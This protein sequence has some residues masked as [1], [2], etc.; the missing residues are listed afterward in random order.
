VS[1]ITSGVLLYSES[2]MTIEKVTSVPLPPE[3]R[4]F[5]R[6]Q[7][8]EP[9]ICHVHLPQSQ[10]LW[11]GQGLLVN[12]SLGGFYFVCDQQPPIEKDDLCYVTFAT[13]HS[14]LEN[15]HFGFHVSVVRTGQM[16]LYQPKFAMA[17]KI[18]SE[19]VYYS[20][21][22]KN[23]REVTSLDKPRILYQY[24]DLNK[25]AYEIITNTSDIRTEKINKIKRFIETGSYSINSETIAQSVINDIFIEELLL[26]KR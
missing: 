21:H 20:P 16:Q 1:L 12:I 9:R 6:L 19:P 24:Y 22:E 25:K 14:D 15:Y 11:T 4:R 23:K 3:K 7:V 2:S 18:I 5:G 13:P 17:L 8:S 26:T 10:E